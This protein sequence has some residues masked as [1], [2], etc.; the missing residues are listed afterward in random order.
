MV[1]PGFVQQLIALWG[2]LDQ[3]VH[4]HSLN[5][6]VGV[7]EREPDVRQELM[8]HG[9]AQLH[10]AVH[11]AH[12]GLEHHLLLADHQLVTADVINQLVLAQLQELFVLG[13]VLERLQ[14]E[15]P[16]LGEERLER[17]RVG[18]ALDAQ[19]VAG[20]QLL[21]QELG[22]GVA[23][24]AD[25]EEARRFKQILHVLCRDLHLAR[26][27]VLQKA[28]HGFGED[29]VDLHQHL[30]ALPVVVAEH[31]SEVA[32]AGWEHGAVARELPALHADDDICEQPAVSE[33]IEDLEDAFCVGWSRGEVEKLRAWQRFWVHFKNFP[34]GCRGISYPA[35]LSIQS[36]SQY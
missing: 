29:A 1:S 12:H 13:H 24:D 18:E 5:E 22:A 21:L 23:Q 20:V 28:I 34:L 8:Q 26:V 36:A 4:F 15:V 10:G 14:R 16:A 7:Q 17:V 25:L 19:A 3:L 32:A 2:V 31:G 27:H 35:L 9:P 30:P 33:F 6:V 11:P